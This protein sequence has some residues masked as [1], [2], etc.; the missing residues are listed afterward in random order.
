MDNIHFI[1]NYKYRLSLK[2]HL[3][4]L[5]VLCYAGGWAQSTLLT[6]TRILNKQWDAY[7]ITHAEAQLDIAGVFEFRKSVEINN[8]PA[9]M[10]IHVSA[11]QRYKLYV[12]G[13]YICNGPARGNLNNWNFETIDIAPYLNKGKNV[14]AALVWNCLDMLPIAQDTYW[15]TGFILQADAINDSVFNTNETWKVLHDTAY[16]LYPVEGLFAYMAGPGEKFDGSKHPWKWKEINYNDS[17]WKSALETNKGMPKNGIT[18]QWKPERI[19]SARQIPAMERKQ[20]FF[21]AIRRAE[22]IDATPLLQQKELTIPANVTVKILLDQGELTT[23][24]PYLRFS[25]GKGAAI[26]LTYAESLFMPGDTSKKR[27]NTKDMQ[28][29]NRD[30]IDGKLVIGNYDIFIADGAAN[31]EVE[32]L[33]WRCFRYVQVE[34][35]TKEDPFVLQQPGSFFTAYPLQQKAT[36]ASSKPILADIYKTAWHTQHLCAGETFFDCPYYEQMQYVGDTR[37]QGLVTF[38]GSG[39]STLWRKAITDFYDSRQ[40]FG[41]V[42][43]AYPGN[44]TQVIPGYSLLWIA[45]LNDYRLHCSD[46]ALIMKML[47]AVMDNL[48]WFQDHLQPNGMLG[49]LEWWNFIDWVK[50]KSWERGVPSY[51]KNGQSSINSLLY[52]Y[53]LQQAI[54]LL[55]SYGYTQQAARYAVIAHRIKEAVY[56]R[57]W[58]EKKQ[59]LADNADKQHYS[60]HA[61]IL[62]T[63]VDLL[64]LKKLQQLM[65]NT[66]QN[67]SIA[68]CSYYFR[69]YLAEAMKKTGL[70]GKYIDMLQPWQNMLANGLT[71]FSEEPEPSRSDCHAWSA[72]PLYHL[73]SLVCGIQPAAAGF[74][75]VQIIPNPGNLEWFEGSMPHKLGPIQVKLNQSK[76][77]G[78]SGIVT[79]PHKLYGYFEW[80]GKRIKLQPG[81]NN[82]RM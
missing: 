15:Q 68:S 3:L 58:D 4:A 34:V 10:I 43:C 76:T 21:K 81:V 31:R 46:D 63:L 16:S 40:P 18:K 22:G 69:F 64:P 53:S 61:Q 13:Q 82:I 32:S 27:I 52:V 30:S 8:L 11:D 59:L 73:L 65:L 70:G 33:W 17:S 39:D 78:L 42:M 56:K 49:K 74:N 20:Q 6:N 14:V 7:W 47:P 62:A 29:G 9:S 2:F 66:Y 67:D 1:A 48:Q 54:E 38:Y 75:K 19:L 25:R 41:L 37:L 12:N 79:L 23:A 72:T 51:D 26:K 35:T 50:D 45:M 71:T 5:A 36:F 44:R 60:Q 80:K 55:N 57:C 24:Y 28:K 77:G